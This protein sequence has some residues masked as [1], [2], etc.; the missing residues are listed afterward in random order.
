MTTPHPEAPAEGA[1]PH[2][3][4][5]SDEPSSDEPSS[6]EPSSDEPSSHDSD[7]KERS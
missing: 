3:P 5:T 6:D 2:A 1:D 7:A 4:E